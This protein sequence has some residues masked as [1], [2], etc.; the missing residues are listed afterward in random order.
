MAGWR[1]VSNG[2]GMKFMILHG[3]AGKVFFRQEKGLGPRI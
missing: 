1:M 3:R 2:S